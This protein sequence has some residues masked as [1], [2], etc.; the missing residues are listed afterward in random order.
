ME[1]EG[2]KKIFKLPNEK[3]QE[4]FAK[5]EDVIQKYIFDGKI[6]MW[7]LSGEFGVTGEYDFCP[8]LIKAL[9]EI[10]NYVIQL[11]DNEITEAYDAITKRYLRI[12]NVMEN[13]VWPI[14]MGENGFIPHQHYEYVKNVKTTTP[15]L[16]MVTLIFE[17]YV[18]NPRGIY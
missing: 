17:G 7:A 12:R 8:M 15:I 6:Q 16:E 1:V 2:E 11:Q 9:L 14:R 13:A 5:I 3:M 18:K 10:T 4:K